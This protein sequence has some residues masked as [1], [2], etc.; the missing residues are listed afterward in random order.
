[1]ISTNMMSP[2]DI[3]CFWHV[4]NLILSGCDNIQSTPMPGDVPHQRGVDDDMIGLE[5]RDKITS[6]LRNV[7]GIGHMK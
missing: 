5:E 2:N 1:M 3:S 4:F 6:S 7:D